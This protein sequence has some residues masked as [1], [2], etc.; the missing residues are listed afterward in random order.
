[1][2]N[3]FIYTR[4]SHSDLGEIPLFILLLLVC[5][6]GCSLDLSHPPLKSVE[7]GNNF[8]MHAVES[9]VIHSLLFFSSK[10][11]HLGR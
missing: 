1:M 4:Y 8:Y 7:N 3:N 2:H 6:E 5:V 9:S 11:E 10:T